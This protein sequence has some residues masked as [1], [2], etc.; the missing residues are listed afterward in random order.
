MLE[1]F[2]EKELVEKA[3]VAIMEWMGIMTVVIVVVMIVVKMIVVIVAVVL[4]SA[5]ANTVVR[6]GVE[7]E[8]MYGGEEDNDDKWGGEVKSVEKEGE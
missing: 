1:I 7:S 3:M 4:V 8:G 6:M 5:L 2:L